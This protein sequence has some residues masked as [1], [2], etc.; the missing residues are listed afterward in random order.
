MN[1][2]AELLLI[3]SVKAAGI[4]LLVLL[5]LRLAGD[6]LPP[7]FRH[8]LWCLVFLR[9]ALPILPTS[10]WSLFQLAPVDPQATPIPGLTAFLASP[11]E[12]AAASQRPIPFVTL[13]T[14]LWLLGVAFFS[15]RR[16]QGASWL[17][18]KIHR[19]TPVSDERVLSVF[20]RCRQDLGVSRPVELLEVPEFPG[21]ATGG[22]WRHRILLPEDFGRGLEDDELRHVFL[23]ELSHIRRADAAVLQIA[24]WLQVL[25]WFNP[26]I[27]AASRRL[28][29]ESEL[30]CDAAVL[31]RLKPQERSRYGFTLLR[32]TT[33]RPLPIPVLGI[34]SKRELTWRINMIS[35]FHPPTLLRTAFAG[36]LLVGLAVVGLTEAVPASAASKA[37]ASESDM[38]SDMEKVKGTVVD[39]RTT[40][41]AMFRWHE[42]AFAAA[43]AKPQDNDPGEKSP[44]W[45]WRDCKSISHQDLEAM[46]VPEFIDS[47]PAKDPWGNDYEFCLNPDVQAVPALGIRGR[48]SDGRFEGYEY[49]VGG[50]KSS[51][52]ERDIVWSDGYFVTWPSAKA[53]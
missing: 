43:G 19:G 37:S 35:K 32:L 10:P 48:G 3:P 8:G 20:R 42:A 1:L 39:I 29:T 9:L 12:V 7:A 26:L 18:K 50:F 44:S 25:H 24:G 17:R 2:A 51:R 53:P 30:A 40:G 28:S 13:L 15:L 23:H 49:L 31:E 36:A 16:L 5:V 21:P 41:T 46:L 34:S 38:A 27:H 4:A 22:F 14:G 45:D 47:V 6:R 11:A 33:D 52:T